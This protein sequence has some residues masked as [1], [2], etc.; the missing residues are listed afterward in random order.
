VPCLN[1]RALLMV[2]MLC[3]CSR[4]GWWPLNQLPFMALQLM[5]SPVAGLLVEVIEQV[6]SLR[7]KLNHQ[8]MFRGA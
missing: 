3:R 1:L 2:P 6:V 8:W 7:L 4:E 5:D